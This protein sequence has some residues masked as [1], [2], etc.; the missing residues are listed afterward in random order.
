MKRL[1]RATG[2]SSR[3]DK[4]HLQSGPIA[5]I[6]ALFIYPIMDACPEEISISKWAEIMFGTRER[7]IC[8]YK[9]LKEFE[10]PGI[11]YEEPGVRGWMDGT[12]WRRC[13]VDSRIWVRWDRVFPN[14]IDLEAH[15]G[16][17]RSEH[18]FRLTRDEWRMLRQSGALTPMNYEET[19]LERCNR[20]G[21][22]QEFQKGD[23][24]EILWRK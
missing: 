16:Y 7:V 10:I 14:R 6:G 18:V 8:Q 9:V 22:A 4:A 24:D 3:R 12:T 17:G 1:S 15:I 19:Y 21:R 20:A 5:E 2:R 13:R 11:Y 23:E